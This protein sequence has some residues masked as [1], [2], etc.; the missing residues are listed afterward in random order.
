MP[1]EPTF[2]FNSD[3]ALGRLKEAY[4]GRRIRMALAANTLVA[5]LLTLLEF[6]DYP[7]HPVYGFLISFIFTHCIGLSIYTLVT[8]CVFVDTWTPIKRG[9]GMA[10]FFVLGGW[11]GTFIGVGLNLLLVGYQ[12]DAAMLLIWLRTNSLLALV[13]GSIIMLYFVLSERLER[14]ATELAEKKINE[15][16]LERLKTKAELEALRAKV[17]PHFLFN[18]LNSIA[19]LIPTDPE[20]AETMVLRLS[21]LFRYALNASQHDTVRLKD[22]LKMIRE[23]LEIEKVRLGHRLEYHIEVEPGLENIDLPG[24]LLQPLVENGV[25]HGIAPIPKG[26][27]VSVRCFSENGHCH[28]EVA[29]TGLG[30]KDFKDKGGFGLRGVCERLE[31]HYGDRHEFII[32]F[33]AGACITLKLP[34][35]GN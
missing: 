27:T 25:K 3:T 14:T 6:N 23:Y 30:M 29:D 34:L 12:I 4:S 11:I 5:V 17:S 10:I 32:G 1:G 35:A 13:F 22:E 24:L 21:D 16:H 20:K 18:T 33:D 8:L 28:I 19:S 31:L 26:G 9:L 2:K 15:Q 7:G